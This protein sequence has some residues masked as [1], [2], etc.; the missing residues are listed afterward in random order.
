MK[1]FNIKSLK[2]YFENPQDKIK[3]FL[4]IIPNP[5]ERA[6]NFEFILK[7]IN[8]KKFNISRFPK[9]DKMVKIINTFQSPSL[10]GGDPL[11]II[12]DLSVFKKED[13][14]SLTQFVKH[15]DVNLIM[16]AQKKQDAFQIYSLVE[17][18]GL[19]FDLSAEKIWEKEKR[20]ADFSIEK[21]MRAKKNISSIV[22]EALFDRVGLDLA[23]LE[24]EIEKLITYAIDKKSIE[25]D[26]VKNI[27]VI[28]SQHT[29]WQ[30]S[31]EIVWGKISF[32]NFQVDAAHFH[33]LLSTIRYQLQV[34]L[35]MATLIEKNRANEFTKYFPR[36]YPRALQKKKDIAANHKSSFYKKSIQTLFEI[37]LLSKNVNFNFSYLLDLLKTK[38][39]YLSTYDSDII[40]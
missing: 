40:T 6:K 18:K 39:Y 2:K 37:D 32:D 23:F 13:L 33:S 22:I 27:C 21:C 11:V 16:G 12:D 1:H 29:I 28:N 4:S 31:E 36:I 24:Q 5:Y 7:K 38:L 8:L 34:G 26:D 10:L 30:I 25:L 15:N 35:K 9:E 20:L 14:L 17:K 3:I 19:I